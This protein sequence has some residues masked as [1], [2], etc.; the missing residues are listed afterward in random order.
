MAESDSQD[1]APRD[2]ELELRVDWDR[3]PMFVRPGL[4][5]SEHANPVDAMLK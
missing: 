3:L 4:P 2:E 1:P 5:V